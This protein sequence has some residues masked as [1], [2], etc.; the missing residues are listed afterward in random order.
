M[1]NLSADLKANTSYKDESG[2]ILKILEDDSGRQ[3]AMETRRDMLL[4]NWRDLLIERINERLSDESK[5]KFRTYIRTRYN[6][7]KSVIK[8][9]SNIY[10]QE[11]TRNFSGPNADFFVELYTKIDIN[12]MMKTVNMYMNAMN[13]TLLHVVYDKWRKIGVN[14]LTPNILTVLCDRDSPTVPM[15]V[16][17]KK[18]RNPNKDYSPSN[19][20]WNTWTNDYHYNILGTG[21]SVPISG[22]EGLV[23][24]WG[25]LPFVVIHKEFPVDGFW[26]NTSGDTLFEFCI[27]HGIDD[28]FDGFT[29]TWNSFKSVGATGNDIKIASGL[30]LSPDAVFKVEGE[31]VSLQILDFQVDL[32]QLREYR[33]ASLEMLAKEFGI[34]IGNY[35]LSDKLSGRALKIKNKKLTEIREEQEKVLMKAEFDLFEMIKKINAITNG[36]NPES[37]TTE[38][39]LQYAEVKEFVE[40]IDELEIHEKEIEMNLADVVEVFMQRNPQYAGN[41]EEAKKKLIEIYKSNNEF[42]QLIDSVMMDELNREDGDEEEKKIQKEVEKKEK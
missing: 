22:N 18:R 17:I 31:D 32:K 26:N 4:E 35:G 28:T 24:P 23:N 3:D 8:E 9:I 11:P 1:D 38:M 19:R 41:Y 20:Y 5:T 14:I 39:E 21:E 37:D 36:K 12:S 33:E 13:E 27:S 25:F 40:P 10:T 16:Y 7:W 2:G 42:R 29:K 34:D 15:E 6:P 30:L